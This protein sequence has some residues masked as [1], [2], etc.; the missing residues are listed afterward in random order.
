[1]TTD[2]AETL[3]LTRTCP[4]APPEQHLRL[5]REQP[6]TKVTLP[7]GSAAWVAARYQDI[8]TVLS[9][10]R[11]SANRRHP[12][13]PRL[14]GEM[15][16]GQ[17]PLPKMMLEMDPPE[18][19]PVRRAVIGEFT[20]RRMAALRPR[21]QQIV[22]EHIDAML[23][24]PRPVDLVRALAL[25]V[26]SLVIC[27]LLGVPYDDHDFFQTNSAQLLDH[28]VT[29][30]ERQ[31][32]ALELV[33]YLDKL[34]TAK[35]ENPG[36]DL[37]GRQVIKQ[38]ESGQED[39]GALLSLAFLLLL[40]GHETTANMISLG[41]YM[42]LRNPDALAALREDPARTP[43]AVEELLR[44]FTI[45]EFAMMRIATEDVELGGTVIPA[46]EG[47]LMLANAGNR[48]PE[49]F[50]DAEAF[51]IERDARSHL[52]FGY[53]PHQCLG[54]N[55]ARVELEIVFDT[56]FRRIPG[57]RPA[58]PDEQLAFKDNATV[59]G[60]HELPVTW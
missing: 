29:A 24:G 15:D 52:A 12:N 8:R 6:V 4:Y 50:Q 39:H 60:M 21:I 34:V 20:V 33:I 23:D 5:L 40:A 43:G 38:R 42:M 37:L 44:H 14:N 17:S 49:V 30:Q 48:D 16:P 2:S 55:L 54:Q 35:E 51:D 18:H 46:G 32:A 28:A 13:A 59:Y 11:F 57:L 58:V 10:P 56:L 41:T 7:G 25:P 1:M 45:A 22:D 31:H 9:D 53:G 26:P 19:G 36:D 3:Q 27:E 47:V